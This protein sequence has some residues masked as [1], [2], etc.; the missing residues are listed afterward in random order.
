MTQTN[1]TLFYI[2][3]LVA[4]FAWGAAWINTKI[5]T[6]YV[7][8]FEL[9]FIRYSLTT[10]SM[11]PIILYLKKSFH[12]D[13]RSLFLVFL[14]AVVLL[15]CMKYSILGT[16]LGTASLGGA[17]VTVLIPINTFIFLSFLNKKTIQKKDA[18]ALSLGA[19]GVLI[20]LN[21]F[22]LNTKDIFTLYNLYFVLAALLWPL[23]SIISSKSKR[24]SPIVYTFYLYLI[25]SILD[26]VFFVDF[27]TIKTEDFDT[28]FYLNMTIIILAATTFGNTIYFLCIEKLGAKEANSF[29]FLVPF[30]A[31]SLGA[32]FLDESISI[33]II[34]GTILTLIAVKLL[35]NISF[36]R[37]KK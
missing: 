26:A 32:I 14:S 13:L 9:I 20:M 37:K 6:S 7:N 10:L 4:M 28:V 3:M 19:F 17:L 5:L 21:V 27:K 11:I 34:I 15:F 36:K 16:K 30:S 33:S 25:T 29:I 23:I 2:L 1:K 18:L 12:I 35:N 8:E 22:S 24:I 31:I